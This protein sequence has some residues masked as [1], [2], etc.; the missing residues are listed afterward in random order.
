MLEFLKKIGLPATVAAVI[1]ALITITPFLFKI[2]ERYAKDDDVK[3]QVLE[4]SK[5]LNDIA[6]ELS[7]LAGT[8]ELLVS[9]VMANQQRIKAVSAPIPVLVEEVKP[10]ILPAASASVPIVPPE[11]ALHTIK[12]DLQSQQQ[13]LE[14]FTNR[15]L[16]LTK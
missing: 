15:A 3:A 12:R 7:K 13:R 11:E 5:E 1:A 4:T 14:V 8:Q 16:I 9:M 6:K 2:D 10:N